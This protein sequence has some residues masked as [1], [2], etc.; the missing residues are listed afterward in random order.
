MKKMLVVCILLL[1]GA[2][3]LESCKKKNCQGLVYD[4][5]PMLSDTGYNTCEAIYYNYYMYLGHGEGQA[6][7]EQMYY[8]KIKAHGYI[9]TYRNPEG[10]Y[11]ALADSPQQCDEHPGVELKIDGMGCFDTIAVDR[12]KKYYITGTM[13]FIEHP[14]RGNDFGACL[15]FIPEILR[16]DSCY[17]E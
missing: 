3:L 7:I 15:T 2:V 17:H 13:G 16:I 6:M 4:N 1:V 14:Y 11:Y 8:S 5:P 10:N 9:Y 12:T